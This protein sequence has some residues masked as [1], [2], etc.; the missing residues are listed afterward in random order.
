MYSLLKHA[1]L[2]AILIAVIILL[3]RFWGVQTANKT[4]NKAIFVIIETMAHVAL[5][6]LGIAL[7]LF[8]KINP[9]Q[10]ENFWILEKGIALIAFVVMT[11]LAV[12][13]DKKK[14]V[15]YLYL[16]GS[17]GWL[18]YAGQIAIS[19]KSILLIG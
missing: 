8:L 3:I 5:L 18:V 11:R 15:Q 19:H 10:S 2:S 13:I 9:F 14:G 7:T 17:F 1:H 4:A 12:N 6:L 16:L